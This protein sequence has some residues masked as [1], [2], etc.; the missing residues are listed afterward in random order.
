VPPDEKEV[1]MKK[2]REG[3]LVSETHRECTVCGDIFK[4]T[5]KTVA[6]CGQCN[7]KRVTG[8][9]PE[10]RMWRRAKRRA[11]E[12][13]IPFSIGVEDITI[14]KVCP[15]LG[16]ELRVFEGASG[17]R[18]FSPSLDKINPLLGYIRGNVW[19]ISHLANR[20]K[21]NADASMLEKF[22][23]WVLNSGILQT[24]SRE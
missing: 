1:T 23:I 8:E 5:S 18:D 21:A 2:N 22:A 24:S 17:G 4:K 19:V 3:Y 10:V 16:I 7:S 15:I 9:P 14:P 13:G 20:M 11:K 6:L 12:Q